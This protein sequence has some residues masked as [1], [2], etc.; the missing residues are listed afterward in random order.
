MMTSTTKVYDESLQERV[1]EYMKNTGISQNKLAPR[2]GVSSASLSNYLR[3]KMEGSVEGIENR[4]RE[5]LQQ[6]SEAAA[7]QVQAAPYNL[8]ETYKPTSISEDV[9]QSIRY[10][11]INRTLV[12]LHGDAGAGKT[13]AAVK[14]Y[15]DNPQSTIYI[16]LDPSMSGLAGVGELLGAALDLPAVS[17]SKQ[18]WQ[19]IRARLRG[20]NKVIIVDEAQLLKRA[21]MDGLRILPDEDEVNEVPG[22]GVVLIGNSEL[23][24]RVKKGKITTQAYTRIGLQRAYSTMRLTN[25]DIKLLFPMFAGEDQAK[26]LKLIASVCRSQHSIRTAKHIVKNAIRNEDISYEGLRAAAAST[27]VGRI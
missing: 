19:A 6:E 21:P 20:T 25:E 4:L 9:Y 26:E 2:V 24:E 10:A 14:Y 18:M 5:F 15:R 17:S 27:P 7:A 23:Y 13:K 11:Q 3:N 1:R 16:R 12:M 22:N 8:D